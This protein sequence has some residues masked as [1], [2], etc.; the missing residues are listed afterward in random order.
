MGHFSL[1]T[2]MQ[3]QS[4][5]SRKLKVSFMHASLNRNQ[6]YQNLNKKPTLA[7]IYLLYQRPKTFNN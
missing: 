5:I 3:A 4:F 7:L 1:H 2:F 6:L